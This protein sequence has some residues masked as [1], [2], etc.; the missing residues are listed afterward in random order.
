[1]GSE[2]WSPLAVLLFA[3]TIFAWGTN[4]LFVRV[5]LDSASPLW[6][7]TLRAGVGALGFGA[8]LLFTHPGTPMPRRQRLT[9]IALGIPN[10]AIFFGLW[11]VAAGA[12]APGQS[13]V[14]IYT[15]PLWVALL[16]I[17]LLERRL[18]W[19]HWVAIALGF[20]GVLLLSQ[21][22]TGGGGEGRLA[23][24]LELVGAAISW[25]TAT[26]LAQRWFR[27]SEMLRVNGYQLAG[28]SVALL[29]ATLL[30]APRPL[31][32]G[33]ESL[34]VATVWLA[35]FG[36]AFAYG[37]WFWLLGRVP[38]STLSTFSFLVPLVALG[39]SALFV[40]E[41]LDVVQGVGVAAVVVGIYGI[42]RAGDPTRQRAPDS[43][44]APH[45]S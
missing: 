34:A 23:P 29:A 20:T 8:Y 30:F 25:A 11:F 41:R 17:P 32:A 27:P 42:A 21:P 28:G 4:Y 40:G 2:R 12:V 35:L 7:A 9:A 45:E 1:M 13:A 39:A 36:T 31:P 10:T 18:R 33:T 37:V 38:A 3:L 24:L 26:V 14:V 16:S 6:L 5:G 43:S 15:F 19:G 44:V 22:W